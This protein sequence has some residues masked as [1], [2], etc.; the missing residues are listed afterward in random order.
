MPVYLISNR[1]PDGYHGSPAA[2][3]AWN[4]WFEQLG[5]HLVDRGNPV[6][7]SAAIG[8]CGPSSRLGGC[9]VITADDLDHATRLAADCPAI[10]AGGG[11]EIGEL[12]IIN[13]RAD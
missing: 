10:A 8:D 12:T 1:L 13:E 9:T 6:F 11:A 3:E 4:T 7:N 5:D 2:M